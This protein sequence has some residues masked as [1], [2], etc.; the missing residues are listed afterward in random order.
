M[1]SY[2][3]YCFLFSYILLCNCF[4]RK[5]LEKFLP[6]NKWIEILML[7]YSNKLNLIFLFYSIL[8]F[9]AS[10]SKGLGPGLPLR[11]LDLYPL[12]FYWNSTGVWPNIAIKLTHLSK[13]KKRLINFFNSRPNSLH[14]SSLRN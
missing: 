10:P 12:K 14:W 3:Y 8:P 13:R 5:S 2:F 9:L 6:L 11:M 7:F 1:E 4:I